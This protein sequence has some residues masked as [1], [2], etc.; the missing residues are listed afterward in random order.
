MSE[1]AMKTMMIGDEEEV[2]SM[3]LVT[4]FAPVCDDVI[5]DDEK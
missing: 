3:K 2:L 4:H 1:C 5:S